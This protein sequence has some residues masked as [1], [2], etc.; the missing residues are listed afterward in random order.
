MHLDGSSPQPGLESKDPSSAV[1]LCGRV[2]GSLCVHT[3]AW[4]CTTVTVAGLNALSF[5][6]TDASSSL[7]DAA[8]AASTR[9]AA[10]RT[11]AARSLRIVPLLGRSTEPTTQ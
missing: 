8:P 11:P 7:A 9:I 10:P 4:P 5:M 6:E 1:T 3:T 2:A